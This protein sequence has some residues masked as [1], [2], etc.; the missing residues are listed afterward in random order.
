MVEMKGYAAIHRKIK[1]NWIWQ[2]KPFS[3][4]QAWI[5]MILKAN[6]AE[7][8][9]N[10]K[11]GFVTIKRGQF[12][13]T[14]QGLADDFGWSRG[15]VRLFISSLKKDNML[16]QEK[17]QGLTILSICNYDEYQFNENEKSPKKSP[18]KAQGKTIGEHGKALNNNKDNNEDNINKKDIYPDWLDMDLW[19]TFLN[20]RKHMNKNKPISIQ[21]EKV[22]ITELKKYVDQGYTQEEIINKTIAQ[23]WKGFFKPKEPP[24]QAQPIFSYQEL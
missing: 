23:G 21:S 16:A 18:K 8:K 1:S 19:K 6:H 24:Q 4:G 7:K 2:D 13:R 3:K 22:N 11:G 9:M 20:H 15:K 12:A 10:T 14:E 5:D 17:A